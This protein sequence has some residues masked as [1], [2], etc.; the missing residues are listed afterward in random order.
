MNS[1]KC[2]NP[3]RGVA[4][5]FPEG[6]RWSGG[7]NFQAKCAKDTRPPGG[8]PPHAHAF[9]IIGFQHLAFMGGGAM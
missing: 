8:T 7:R 3:S 6:G 5:D 9:F 4:G 1:V 2:W